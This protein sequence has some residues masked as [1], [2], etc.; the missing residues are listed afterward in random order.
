MTQVGDLGRL[1]RSLVDDRVVYTKDGA[2]LVVVTIGKDSIS[3]RPTVKTIAEYSCHGAVNLK[4][5]V[6]GVHCQPRLGR[7]PCRGCMFRKNGT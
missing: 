1:L 5:L 4:G 7:G 3:I 2:T 6:G